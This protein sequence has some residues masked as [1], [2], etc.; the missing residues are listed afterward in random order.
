M[1]YIKLLL[2]KLKQKDVFIYSQYISIYQGF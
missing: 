1:L 2:L